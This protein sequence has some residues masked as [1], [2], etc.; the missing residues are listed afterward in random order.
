MI[1]VPW[2][3]TWSEV[4]TKPQITVIPRGLK[5]VWFLSPSIKAIHIEVD[6]S[7]PSL[8]LMGLKQFYSSTMQTFPL[9]IKIWLVLE[10]HGLMNSAACN[11]A[12]GLQTHQAWFL[13]CTKTHWICNKGF[14]HSHMTHPL[15]D[16]LWD[17][18]LSHWLDTK[19]E[20]PLFHAIS[21][22]ATKDGYL[23]R[24]LPQYG[25]QAHV[26]I[27]KLP[28]QTARRPT[29]LMVVIPAMSLQPNPTITG[30]ATA[31]SPQD[32]LDKLFKTRFTKPWYLSMLPIH[33]PHTTGA[34]Q[35]THSRAQSQQLPTIPLVADIMA[36][37][38]EHC[39]G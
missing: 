21:P 29:A 35:D 9:G 26:A 34:H 38:P 3:W 37:V 8:Q 14:H 31:V 1:V 16:T 25:A 5:P 15:Y 19:S 13:E 11:K 6:N 23:V 10:L 20:Q 39:L 24:Y 27:D 32:A 4:R 22:M 12:I 18:K 30:A 7:I 33:Q 36:V 17:M 28:H 2:W